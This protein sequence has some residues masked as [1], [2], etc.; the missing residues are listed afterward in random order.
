M[1][2]EFD[3]AATSEGTTA[4]DDL[5]ST[6]TSTDGAPTQDS[7]TEALKNVYDPEL[8][9]NIVDLGLVYEV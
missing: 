6:P 8:G 5:T 9:I 3:N 1:Q 2:E 7:V 4:V